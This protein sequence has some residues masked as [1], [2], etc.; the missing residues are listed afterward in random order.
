MTKIAGVFSSSSAAA[1]GLQ[2]NSKAFETAAAKE[3]VLVL[4]LNLAAMP[5]IF[6][7]HSLNAE[8]VKIER[9][10]DVMKKQAEQQGQFAKQLLESDSKKAAPA[11]T[12]LSK[13]PDGDEN[14]DKANDS[15]IRNRGSN[16]AGADEPKAD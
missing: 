10:R 4:A 13:A 16:K 3:G 12:K 8:I 7:I 14:E 15:E 11:E 2:D 1:T 9:D 6:V 5:A